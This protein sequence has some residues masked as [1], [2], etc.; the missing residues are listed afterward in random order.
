[1]VPNRSTS[2]SLSELNEL[3]R[4]NNGDAPAVKKPDDELEMAKKMFQKHHQQH[5]QPP[6]QEET[7]DGEALA[8]IC[9]PKRSRL[10][11]KRKHYVNKHMKWASW[12]PRRGRQVKSSKQ[13]M[14]IEKNDRSFDK[15]FDEVE[16]IKVPPQ[17][18]ESVLVTFSTEE[19]LEFDSL[20][21]A[22][23]VIKNLKDWVFLI[24]L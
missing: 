13:Q 1:M 19:T 8:K 9:L 17:Y 22:T 18:I 11:Q 2:I 10:K 16:L 4:Q 6:T 7:L 12:K 3:I 20:E 15:I 14:P 23:E 24:F 21:H 5:L